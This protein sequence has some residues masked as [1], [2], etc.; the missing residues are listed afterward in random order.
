MY[1]KILSKGN[2]IYPGDMV[3][4]TLHSSTLDD[5]DEALVLYADGYTDR[6]EQ[7]TN[8]GQIP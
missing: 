3:R 1:T 4:Y 5:V 2:A 8:F 6:S 7:S